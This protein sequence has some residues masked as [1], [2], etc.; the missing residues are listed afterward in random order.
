MSLPDYLDEIKAFLVN[1]GLS[2]SPEAAIIL[3]SGLGGFSKEIENP[4]A[5]PYSTIPHFPDSS[6]IGHAGTLISGEV[7]GKHVVAFSG[8]FH[9]YEGFTFEQTVLPVYV[10]KSLNARKLIISNAA[11]AINTSFSVGDLMVI[12]DVIRQNLSIAPREHTPFR[13][14]HHQW[15]DQVRELAAELQIPVRHGTY[16]YA[17]GPNYESK[18]EIRAFRVMGADAVGMSTAPELM[19]AARLGIKTAAISLIS[20]MAAGVTD[21]KLNHEE[22]S[23]AAGLRKEEFGELVKILI[24]KF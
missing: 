18:A 16:I 21:R 8:R 20:N 24:Q 14:R 7:E 1:K 5:I 6:V 22:V 2:E 9:H 17:K 11:G 13:Y 4:N 15:V 3:G 19:E 12:E 10:A 23:E